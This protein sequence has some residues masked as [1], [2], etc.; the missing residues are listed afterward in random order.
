[1][2]A[3]EWFWVSFLIIMILIWEYYRYKKYDSQL[4]DAFIHIN[5]LNFPDQNK[6]KEDREKLKQEIL[7]EL[8][9]KSCGGNC[10]CGNASS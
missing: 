9:K 4:E 1:M 7:T 5:R 6:L 2:I 8:N 3:I 10:G